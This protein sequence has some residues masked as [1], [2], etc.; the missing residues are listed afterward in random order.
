ME[1]QAALKK[2]QSGS[3]QVPDQEG[4]AAVA[5]DILRGLQQVRGTRQSAGNL[6]GLVVLTFLSVAGGRDAHGAAADGAEGELPASEAG[7]AAAG[8]Y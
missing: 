8:A 2:A 3:S 7:G 1:R 4:G 5:E 6:R